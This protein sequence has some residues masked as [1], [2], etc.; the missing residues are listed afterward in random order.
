MAPLK[1][2][3]EWKY[4]GK[5]DPLWGVASWTN[6]QKSGAEPW[7]DAE[8]YALGASDWCDFVNHWEQYGVKRGSCVEIG[9]GAGRMTR[10]LGQ[11]FGRVYALDV[12]ADMIERAR[13]HVGDNVEFAVVDGLRIPRPDDS[14]DAVFSTHV[15][16]HLDSVEFGYEYFREAYRVLN[17]GGSLMVH[18]PLY[19]WPNDSGAMGAVWRTLYRCFR[20]ISDLRADAS[21]KAGRPMM[22]GTPY[23]IRPLNEFLTELGF[24]GVQVRVFPISSNG[25]LHPFVFATK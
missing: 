25:G 3:T 13:P 2:N 22:R 23:A 10:Q 19:Q 16:Q 17:D 6:R 20:K 18:L 14:E 12:S 7:T 5:S 21:R 24:K 15:L 9:C 11:Y 8:F 4:W 1:S